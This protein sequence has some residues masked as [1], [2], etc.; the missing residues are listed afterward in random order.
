MKRT[1]KEIPSTKK[2]VEVCQVTSKYNGRYGVVVSV[3]KDTNPGRPYKV[4]FN[5][6]QTRRLRTADIKLTK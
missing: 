6:G 5:D 1:K 4:R 2:V 3:N